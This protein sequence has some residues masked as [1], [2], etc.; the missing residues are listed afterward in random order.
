MPSS[1]SQKRRLVLSKAEEMPPVVFGVGRPEDDHLGVLECVFEQVVLLGH[2]HAVA[3]APHGN[4][5][6]VPALRAVGV[7][8]RLH[9]P[10][11][12]QKAVVGAVAIADVAP[13]VVR[14]RRRQDRARALFVP[15][16]GDL[17]G[18]DVER[19]VPRDRLVARDAAVVRV[20]RAAVIEVDPFEGRHD[21]ARRVDQR[22]L[23]LGVRRQGRLARR[24]ERAA[25]RHDRPVALVVGVEL[26]GGH[27]DDAAVLHVDEHGT[28]RRAVGQSLDFSHAASTSA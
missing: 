14:A 5:A 7:W 20:A 28:A 23:H 17:V 3:V 22:A 13:Q 24:G 19:L 27:A 18:D 25:A 21:A 1:F 9:E 6:P 2:A 12:V 15:A 8:E 16:A 11:E 26:D 4:G 10:H